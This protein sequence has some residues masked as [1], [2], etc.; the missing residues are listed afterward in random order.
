MKN[1]SSVAKKQSTQRW[2]EWLHSWKLVCNKN[3]FM[4]ANQI[5][6]LGYYGILAIYSITN[7]VLLMLAVHVA[8]A[9][10]AVVAFVFTSCA[11]I[12]ELIDMLVTVNP[13]AHY[14]KS[15]FAPKHWALAIPGMIA[16]AFV[17]IILSAYEIYSRTGNMVYMQLQSV[18][19]CA[20]SVPEWVRL[21]YHR[22]AAMTA[23]TYL[24]TNALNLTHKFLV[25]N[26]FAGADSLVKLSKSDQAHG[27]SPSKKLEHHNPLFAKNS[28]LSRVLRWYVSNPLVTF[29]GSLVG[30]SLY[31]I[32]DSMQM[33]SLFHLLA[34]RGILYVPAVVSV[35]LITVFFV[36][37][38][39]ERL[40]LWGYNFHYFNETTVKEQDEQAYKK[41]HINPII[42]LMQQD[43]SVRMMFTYGRI[44]MVCVLDIAGGL[45]HFSG[46]AR[47]IGVLTSLAYCIQ[48]RV[49]LSFQVNDV[50]KGVNKRA[51]LVRIKNSMLETFGLRSRVCCEKSSCCPS[52]Q[53][54][55]KTP[56]AAVT[57]AST[58]LARI[59][60]YFGR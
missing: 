60:K 20:I 48:Q 19:D 53:L 41:A 33:S 26:V 55:V 47:L 32:G 17:T 11:I 52:K 29:I 49:Q 6:F 18:K 50:A 38:M 43:S 1:I 46:M 51:A 21:S 13:K 57:P 3:W 12:N 5:S 56:R 4:A 45:L 37:T 8:T 31:A 39:S 42:D 7:L 36:C 10:A 25:T 59:A 2:L 23:I 22:V 58:G 16:G 14:Y 9:N 40:F 35:P 28:F 30:A 34:G 24:L 27:K 44:M 54:A 15:W